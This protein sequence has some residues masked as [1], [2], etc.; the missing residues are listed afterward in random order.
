MQFMVIGEL[1]P[2]LLGDGKP[3]D[4]DGLLEQEQVYGA[5]Y[6]AEGIVKQA[7]SIVGVLGAVA[8]FEAPNRQEF[9][10]LFAGLPLVQAGY[11]QA[12]IIEL[13][14]YKGIPDQVD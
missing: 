8:I 7:W 3:A 9:D 5:K 10:K 6:L 13:E 14:E 4:L 2:D 11:V 1:R 12:R